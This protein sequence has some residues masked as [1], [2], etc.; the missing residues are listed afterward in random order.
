MIDSVIKYYKIVLKNYAKFD[1]RA[2]RAEYWYFVL[3]NLFVS[4][5]LGIISSIIGDKHSIIS[6]LYSLALIIPSIAVAVRRL[7]DIG[8][9]GWWWLLCLIPIIGWIW[10][11]IL[12]VKDSNPGENKYGQNPKEVKTV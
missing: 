7:H 11:I 1:G 8:K 10:I 4:I 12:L 5:I 2:G 6:N 3:C 9:S